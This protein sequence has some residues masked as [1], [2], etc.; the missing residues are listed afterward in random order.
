MRVIASYTKKWLIYIL[1]FFL[2]FAGALMLSEFFHEKK[3]RI[4]A[5]NENLENYTRITHGYVRKYKMVERDDFSYLDSLNVIIDNKYIRITVIH[6]DG[7]VLY[8]SRVSNPR[9]MENHLDRPEIRSSLQNQF[10]THVR[11][12]GT[13]NIKYYYYARNFGRYFI[14]VSDVYDM[15]ARKFIQPD[16]ILLM[17]FILA[18]LGASLTIILLTDKFGKS[19]STLREFTLKALANKPINEKFVFPENELGDIGQEIIEIYQKL[20]NTKEELLSEKSKLIRHLNMLDEGIAIFSKERHVITSNNNFIKF[21]NYLSDTRVFTADEFFR[22]DN[23][24]PIFTFINR[25]LGTANE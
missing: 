7:R 24:A 21:I 12:S 23:F 25:T 4:E 8:D 16:R 3:F 10:G 13:T 5:L 6:E 15:S 1:S 22:V 19:I 20:N 17:I 14:R 11:V 9:E 18:L 2:F